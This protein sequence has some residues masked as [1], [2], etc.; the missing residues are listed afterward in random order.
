MRVLSL[1]KV[2]AEIN[3]ESEGIKMTFKCYK[4][5]HIFESGEESR[6]TESYGEE[7]SGCPLCKG[8]YEKTVRCAVCFSEHLED[9]LSGG[10]CEECIENYQ[11]DIDM[12]LKAGANDT[13][14]IELNCFLA[15][16]FDK[17]EIEEILFRELKEAEKYRQIDCGRFIESDR[18]WFAERLAEEVKKNEKGK[19]Q[20]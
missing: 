6:W 10:V 19:K 17:E 8:E 20:S 16:M 4:C 1:T 7:M 12:C 2:K 9:E 14:E 13:S 11:H 5:G 3:T 15:S 18:D